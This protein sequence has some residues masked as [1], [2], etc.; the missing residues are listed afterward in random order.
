MIIL[1]LCKEDVN[2][3]RGVPEDPLLTERPSHQKREDTEPLP[4]DFIQELDNLVLKKLDK[5]LEGGITSKEA[6]QC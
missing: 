3:A 4:D 1:S 2:D 6:R 5:Q